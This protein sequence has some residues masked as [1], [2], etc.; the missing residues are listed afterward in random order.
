MGPDNY[1]QAWKAHSAQMRIKFD[2]DLLLIELHNER[3]KQRVLQ[4][5]IGCFLLG[6]AVLSVAPDSYTSSFRVWTSLA[7]YSS[8]F[9][10]IFSFLVIGGIW[11]LWMS[12]Q[13]VIDKTA[14][15]QNGRSTD[16]VLNEMQKDLRFNEVGERWIT[17][18]IVVGVSFSSILSW[19]GSGARL[20]DLWS[21]KQGPFY[22]I[23][24]WGIVTSLW[25]LYRKR[26]PNRNSDESE[27]ENS[28]GSLFHCTKASLRQLDSGYE[29]AIN[30]WFGLF[31]TTVFCGLFFYSLSGNRTWPMI[32]S[33]AAMMSGMYYLLALLI[34]WVCEPKRQR[35]LTLL[36]S[37]ND[38]TINEGGRTVDADIERSNQLV[39]KLKRFQFGSLVLTVAALLMILVFSVSAMAW[40]RARLT[41][42]AV[43]VE[44]TKSFKERIHE[45]METAKRK[46]GF[47]GVVVVAKKG[48]PI[49]QGSFGYSHLDTKTPNTVDTPFRIASLSKQFTAAAIL[50][51]EAEGKLSIDDPIHKYLP[52]F[53]VEPYRAI[54]LHQLMTHTS[55]LPRVPEDFALRSKWSAMS[56]AATPVYEYVKLAVQVPLKFTPGQGYEYSNFG[57]RI[58]AAV[59][60]R[61]TGQEYADFMDERLFKPLKLKHTGVARIT[62]PTAEA[63]VAEELRFVSL[64]RKTNEP[65]LASAK[66][67]RNYGA[68]Y[69]SG[70]IYASANDLL[71]WDR[72]LADNSFLSKD[73][74]AKLFQ[75]LKENYACGWIVKE[76]GLDSRLYQTHSGVNEGYFSRMMRV[77]EDDLVI[78]ALGNLSTNDQ[79]DEVLEQLFRL[80]RSLPYQEP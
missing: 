72:V 30:L 70:G 40:Q 49:Y 18:G 6:I 7:W 47:S 51:L 56:R 28:N 61:V 29:G 4:F 41:R 58:L 1:Q 69:G 45:F 57:Y 65:R 34:V 13:P 3:R 25:Q 44:D 9:F 21:W 32:A 23:A 68:G 20:S 66:S 16:G 36:R 12:Q 26:V 52:E 35:F 75:P 22:W 27:L 59:I 43:S 60:T 73:Q 42:T 2:P 55:G 63:D 33:C 5:W 78:I 17:W 37:L 31:A 54:T 10:F 11:G 53:A 48:E 77:P 19:V 8:P 38:E 14:A 39:A 50:S 46:T 24:G 80:C 15:L 64:D 76:S 67:D 79:I 71:R 74:T 62:H